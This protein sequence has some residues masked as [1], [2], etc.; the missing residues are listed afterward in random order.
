M[1]A[2]KA[3]IPG[4]TGRLS[5]G[6]EKIE[7]THMRRATKVNVFTHCNCLRW[8][9]QFTFEFP[10]PYMSKM[11]IVL[12]LLSF[13]VSDPMNLNLLPWEDRCTALNNGLMSWS[14]TNM[15]TTCALGFLNKSWNTSSL[16]NKNTQ[17]CSRY[18]LNIKCSQIFH[19]KR[20]NK[21][22]RRFK[23]SSSHHCCNVS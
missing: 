20:F 10:N 9:L 18:H 13:H 7:C 15:I 16:F 19:T 5:K 12:T 14:S 3:R 1:V 2:H 17:K 4:V 11:N 22:I 6:I 23:V 8:S 21:G